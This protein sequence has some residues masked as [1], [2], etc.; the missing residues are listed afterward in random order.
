V[1]YWI[2]VQVNGVLRAPGGAV[3]QL[4][5]V[6]QLALLSLAPTGTLMVLPMVT[7]PSW[8]T[9]N[10]G[11]GGQIHRTHARP[12]QTWSDLL[13]S[14][15]AGKSRAGTRTRTRTRTLPGLIL[16]KSMIQLSSHSSFLCWYRSHWTQGQGHRVR[17]TGSQGQG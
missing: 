16:L 10:T 1:P 14:F 7:R 13:I 17:V 15:R 6:T 3:L 12:Q 2:P 8:S 9:G 4:R 5:P 11:V